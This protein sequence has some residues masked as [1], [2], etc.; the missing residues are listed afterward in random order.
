MHFWR[1]RCVVVNERF[2]AAV[3]VMRGDTA[4]LAARMLALTTRQVCTWRVQ[5]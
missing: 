4:D 1:V 3:Q 5:E 2:G